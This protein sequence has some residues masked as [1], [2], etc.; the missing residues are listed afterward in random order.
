MSL[1]IIFI[2]KE[3]ADHKEPMKRAEGSVLGE[4]LA[5]LFLNA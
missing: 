4:F 3:K 2:C 5:K 1:D